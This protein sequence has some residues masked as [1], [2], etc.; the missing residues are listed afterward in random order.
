MAIASVIG[1]V[2]S[3][4]GA[5]NEGKA[6]MQSA[7]SA[8]SQLEARA[9]EERAVAQR[10]SLEQQRRGRLL[11]SEGQ[12]KVAAGGGTLDDVGVQDVMSEIGAESDYRSMLEIYEGEQRARG[13][14]YQGQVALAEGKAAKSASRTKALGNVFS[15]A[16]SFYSNY[17]SDVF[18]GSNVREIGRAEEADLISRGW[19]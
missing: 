11:Q 19:A 6:A 8:N 15:G 9:K 12:A 18:G 13:S 4:V 3:T 7:R 17:G 2:V 5:L 16:S 10:K 14:E 1:T